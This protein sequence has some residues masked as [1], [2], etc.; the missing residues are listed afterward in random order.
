MKNFRAIGALA[1][2]VGLL[3]VPGQQADAHHDDLRVFAD[4]NQV[5]YSDGGAPGYSAGDTRTVLADLRNREGKDRGWAQWVCTTTRFDNGGSDFEADCDANFSLR[6]GDVSAIGR[7]TDEDLDDDVV[8]WTIDGGTG[9]FEGA[10]ARSRS[11]CS[12]TTAGCTAT[13]WRRWRRR[14]RGPA[15]RPRAT[16]RRRLATPKNPTSRSPTSRSR[17]SRSR[18]SRSPTSRSR[19]SRTPDEPEPDEPPDTDEP[20]ADGPPGH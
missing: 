14:P 6:N 15:A 3:V 16:A 10:R 2:A 17:T 20:D 5:L 8:L 13:R 18:T 19:T 9:H 1:L 11:G 4:V 12:A 7:L